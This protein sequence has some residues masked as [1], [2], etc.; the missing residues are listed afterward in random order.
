MSRSHCNSRGEIL[1]EVQHLQQRGQAGSACVAVC[2]LRPA[3]MQRLQLRPRL[4]RHPFAICE[5]Q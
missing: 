4:C 1:H 5:K 3:A 2:Q